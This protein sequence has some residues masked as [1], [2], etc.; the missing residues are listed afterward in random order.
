MLHKGYK[1]HF[2]AVDN[3][4]HPYACLFSYLSEQ[5]CLNRSFTALFFYL[6]P[7]PRRSN[8]RHLFLELRSRLRSPFPPFLKTKR[9]FCP[10]SSAESFDLPLAFLPTAL[11]RVY[12]LHLR[13]VVSLL[14]VPFAAAAVGGPASMGPI[15]CL[16]AFLYKGLGYSSPPA[17]PP[18]QR[19]CDGDLCR[20]W[21]F[22]VIY[23]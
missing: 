20:L 17:P 16:S 9:P 10:S 22:Y 14:L 4:C 6:H 3:I 18:P 5:C 21:E 11:A 12:R 2:T 23:A 19:L 8:I 7:H 13:K 1:Y 15:C